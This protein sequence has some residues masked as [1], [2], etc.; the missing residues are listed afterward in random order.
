MAT[1]LFELMNV[2]RDARLRHKQFL[3]RFSEMTCFDQRDKGVEP[4][5]IEHS[6]L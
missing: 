6:L 1:G 4:S 2:L 3:G 5:W